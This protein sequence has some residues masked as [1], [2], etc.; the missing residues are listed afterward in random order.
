MKKPS[1]SVVIPVYNGA[2]GLAGLFLDIK[3]VFEKMGRTFEVIFVDDGSKD[4]S[5]GQMAALARLFPRI[6]TALKLE[7]NCGQH[8]AT[9]CGMARAQG[10]FCITMDDDGQYPASQI[11]RL[12][13]EQRRIGAAVVY[14][15]S[16]SGQPLLR[17]MASF[18]FYAIARLGGFP[19][20]FGS[21]FRLMDGAIARKLAANRKGFVF[22]DARLRTQTG[23]MAQIPVKRLARQHGRSGYG[24]SGLT[25]HAAKIVMVHTAWPRAGIRV[26]GIAAG[27]A[28]SA[29]FAF[30]MF[31]HL[32]GGQ[33]AVAGKLFAAAIV[34]LMG[35]FYADQALVNALE[36]KIEKLNRLAACRVVRK[37]P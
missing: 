28:I 37:L 10:D 26:C 36:R 4:G 17:R 27:I 20:P 9:L 21:S 31:S 19:A 35:I 33:I 22:I 29:F 5:F 12:I 25:G 30:Y 3:R 34:A 1:Y 14:G 24:L 2:N 15:I 8:A 13:D 18:L 6:V 16:K 32:A 11:T 23:K 7:A